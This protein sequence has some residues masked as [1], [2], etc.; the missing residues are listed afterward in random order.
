MVEDFPR[1]TG[2]AVPIGAD[3]SRALKRENY[4]KPE[5]KYFIEFILLTES[6]QLEQTA[7]PVRVPNLLQKNYRILELKFSIYSIFR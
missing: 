6:E 7:L 5:E 1:H 4:C 3:I 2:T